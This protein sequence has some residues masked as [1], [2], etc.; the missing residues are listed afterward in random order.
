MNKQLPRTL[1]LLLMLVIAAPLLSG[2]WDQVEIEDRALV[3]GLSIDKISAEEAQME[4]RV[5]HIHDGGLPAEMISVTAQIAVPG[6]VPL[7]PGTG[8]GS[9]G[10]SKTSPVWV[11][12]V[13]GISLDDAM[14]NLQQQIADPRYLV[15]LRIVIISEDIARGSLAE[16][17]DYL[18]RNPEIRRRTWL[19]VS[20]GRASAFMDVNPP[21]QRVPTLYILSMMEKSVSSGKFPRDYI[22]TFWSADSKWGQ[23]AY[24]PYVALR[25]RDNILIKGLAYF[26]GG[27]MVSKTAPI[28]IGGFM[29]MMGM[30]P[31]GYSTMLHTGNLG[32]V[33]TQINERFTR[34]RSEIRDGKPHLSYH[35]FLEG[36][37]DEH[38]SSDI[39]I[40]SPLKLR[41]IERDFEQQIQTVLTRL[42]KQTQK[43]HSDIFGIGEMIRSHHPAYWKEHVHDKNDWESMYSSVGVDIKLT[44][45]IRR[46][47][48]KHK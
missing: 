25:N 18:R 17:N 6:R 46:V 19:L 22:G 38:Y 24:L 33:M 35:I 27:K 16:L 28:E 42:V 36:D 8:G 45:H 47:G 11:V 20:E 44:L 40:D 12:T 13:Q 3:L 5:T 34:T 14:N 9:A 32:I 15:H 1:A 48:L 43:D 23:S 26:S 30:D 29:A 39:P 37:L 41:E 31:G 10:D 4:D 21:L 7:G 2:C